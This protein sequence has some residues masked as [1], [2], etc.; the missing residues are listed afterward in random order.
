MTERGERLRK[1][2]AERGFAHAT[3]T[4]T[5]MLPTLCP[6]E[7]VRLEG[8]GDIRPGHILAFEQGSGLLV[9]RVIRVAPGHVVCRG[10]NRVRTDGPT[11]REAIV[12][13]A[14]EVFGSE[15][16]RG[17]RLRDDRRALRSIN[18]RLALRRS[19]AVACHVGAELALVWRQAA[20][21]VP[22]EGGASNDLAGVEAALGK[23]PAPAGSLVI[24]AGAYSR[25]SPAA[26][27]ALVKD[28]LLRLEPAASITVRALAS[29]PA[30]RLARAS[31]ALR[32]VLSRVG[33]DAGEPG[34]TTWPTADGKG[35]VVVHLFTAAEFVADLERAGARILEMRPGRQ[36]LVEVWSAT[37]TD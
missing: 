23:G 34:D 32:R 3:V 24:E 22:V 7:I 19:R 18:A 35:H 26:R 37:I 11:P 31:A 1:E 33:I 10:D 4:G 6:D 29:T 2:I 28:A 9:H 17:V 36:Q 15:R 12:G 14:V 21:H 16:S 20:G 5:S 13:R 8:V 30:Q 25:R 27:G